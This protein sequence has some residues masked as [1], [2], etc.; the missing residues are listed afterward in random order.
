MKTNVVKNICNN[1]L[2]VK[3]LKVTFNIKEGFFSK[4]KPLYA[5]NN[6]SFELKKG[7]TL[8]IVGESGCGKSTLIRAILKLINEK[9]AVTG[10]VVW[11]GKDILKFNNKQLKSVRKDIEIIFQDP[12]ASLNPRMNILQIISEPF[13]IHY[14]NTRKDEVIKKVTEVMNQVGLDPSY[15][16]RYPHEFS[17]GQSQRIGIARAIILNPKLVVCDEAVSALDVSIK[18]QIINLLQDLKKDLDIS[19]LFI[20]HDLGIVEHIADRVM[21]LYLG[22]I[23]ELSTAENIYKKPLH[24][25]TKALISAVPVPDPEIEALKTRN[26]IKGEIPS[27][28]ERQKGCPFASRC[29]LVFSKCLKEKPA[30]A[31]VNGTLVACHK[32]T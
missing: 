16:Y 14:P 1:I 20:S 29:T 9:N 13:L 21:V 30:L 15:I 23:M 10:S 6:V 24:P 17:G 32:V 26:E 18:A 3:N 12:L 8:G 19:F 22:E 5:V 25:Y 2:E 27:P 7:E 31:G 28:F 11:L 4:G